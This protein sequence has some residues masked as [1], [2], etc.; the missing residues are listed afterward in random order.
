MSDGLNRLPLPQATHFHPLAAVATWLIPG[1]GHYLLGER[2]RGVILTTSIGLLWMAGV[3][4][5]GVGVCSR[6]ERPFWFLGQMLIAPSWGI[7]WYQGQLKMESGT[8]GTIALADPS[9]SRTGEQGVLYTA[10]AGMLN[11]LA[12]IDVAYR[13]PHEES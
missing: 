13:E 4:L 12:V 1:W 2:K 5:G 6:A 3:T 9:S 11:L 10:L 7:N 8:E